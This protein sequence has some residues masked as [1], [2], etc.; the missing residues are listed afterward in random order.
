MRKR[1][2]NRE[3]KDEDQRIYREYFNITDKYLIQHNYDPEKTGPKDGYIIFIDFDYDIDYID[4]RDIEDKQLEK[5]MNRYVAKL[6][7]AE[8]VPTKHLPFSVQLEFKRSLGIGYIHAFNGQF[9]DIQSIIDNATDYLKK[10]NREFSRT[11]FLGSGIPAAVAS[12]ICGFVFFVTDYKNPW[13]YGIVFGVLGSF[14]SIWSRYGK[15]NNSGFGGFTLHALECYS[16]I[17]IGVIFAIIAMVCIR[18]EL[19]LP[20]LNNNEELFAFIIAAF[21]AAF[22]ERFMPSIIERITKE[23]ENEDNTAS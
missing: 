6:Q 8:A 7:L 21:I 2:E 1:E 12:L 20:N 15:V 10:R 16:R 22:S 19:I 11:L 9:D 23:D 18:C 4:L 3:P 5:E 17:I 13:L 14:V